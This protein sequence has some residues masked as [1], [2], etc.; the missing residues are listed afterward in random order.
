[1]NLGPETE[2]VEHKESTAEVDA[3]YA[4]IAAM[5][6]KHGRGEAFFGARDSGDVKG[7]DVS[8]QTL[9][10]VTQRI[11][12]RVEPR[13]APVVEA[14]TTDDGK[15]YILVSFEGS[16]APYSCTGRYRT[17]VYDEGKAMTAAQVE[18]AFRVRVNRHSPWE[19]R[20]SGKT[21][22]DLEPGLASASSEW[23]TPGAGFPSP[24]RTTPTRSR[25]SASAL[26]TEPSRTPAR[27]SSAVGSPAPASPW[28]SSMATTA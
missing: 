4:S 8:R 28:A 27:S 18:E 23:A 15:T 19:A 10:K 2:C 14:H 26:P 5:L 16:E 9:H 3:A 6:N 17:R 24:T 22:A 7:Q 12:Q 25:A 13:V 20:P 21:L 11:E 1:M